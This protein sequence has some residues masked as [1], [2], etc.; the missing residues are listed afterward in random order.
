[1]LIDDELRYASTEALGYSGYQDIESGTRTVTL[2][3]GSDG[4]T[5]VTTSLSVSNDADYTLVAW[6]NA[7]SSKVSV[8]SENNGSAASGHALVRVFNAS[9]DA[10][11]IDVFITTANAEI[12]GVPATLSAIAAGS[13][14]SFA[15][16]D[17]GPLRLRVTGNGQADDIRLDTSNLSLADRSAV[18]LVLTSGSGG[19]LVHAINA[20]EGSSVAV[21]RNPAARVRAAAA[22]SDNATVSVN[23]GGRSI[24]ASARAPAIGGYALVDTESASLAASINGAAIPG[25]SLTLTGGSDYSLVI[26]GSPSAGAADTTL[27]ADG[28]Y[29]L[30][31][32]GIGRCAHGCAQEGSVADDRFTG[33]QA[34][35]APAVSPPTM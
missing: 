18:T 25:Q 28:V 23:I 16:T 22:V 19:Y 24:L 17:S 5:L 4:Q 27:S 14:S 1:M 31:L 32:L 26:H 30:F 15:T 10:G 2:K 9:A 21:M 33:P 13:A 7:S 6:G 12:T 29:T 3:R 11:T 20:Q 34:L 8:L 35:T